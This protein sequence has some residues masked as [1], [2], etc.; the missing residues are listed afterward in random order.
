MSSVSKG[1]RSATKERRGDVVEVER[2]L[3]SEG[4]TGEVLSLL[5][6]ADG[7]Y[8]VEMA[9]TSASTFAA[10]TGIR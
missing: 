7:A 8:A 9:P 5:A 10:S 2:E 3:L 1:K 6:A 4:R